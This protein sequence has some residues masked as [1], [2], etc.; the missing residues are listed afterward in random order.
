MK[1]EDLLLHALSVGDLHAL[2]E[3]VGFIDIRTYAEL[4]IVTPDQGGMP[5]FGVIGDA[6]F[7]RVYVAAHG[8]E[9]TPDEG[10]PV[11]GIEAFGA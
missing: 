9:P 3:R 1:S 4:R 11:S 5:D 10:G 7:V 8:G 2:L 6:N